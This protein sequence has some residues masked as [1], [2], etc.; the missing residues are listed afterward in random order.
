[1]PLYCYIKEDSFAKE[2]AR[3]KRIKS[4]FSTALSLSGLLMI[5]WVIYPIISF[6]FESRL[7]F[8]EVIAPVV[9]DQEVYALE[10]TDY[11]VLG[12][13][14]TSVDYTQASNWFPNLPQESG[15]SRE[16]RLSIPKLKIDQARVLIGGED[17][18]K[19]LIHY[20]GTGLPGEYGNTVI[21]G[22]SILPQF[23]DPKNYK[24]IFSLLPTLKEN[25]EIFLDYDGLTYRY[26][27]TNMHVINPDDLSV[28]RQKYDGSYVTLITCVPP[29]T[30]WKRLVVESKLVP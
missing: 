12:S 27:V 10:N 29:G 14:G 1:M 8:S 26:V 7:R 5:V 20:G 23:Y 3:K 13:N 21:F 4:L 30:Y 25:D 16:Y 9:E 17:L 24:S 2:Q 22:H 18:N 15:S 6:E 19:S 28:L 11:Q